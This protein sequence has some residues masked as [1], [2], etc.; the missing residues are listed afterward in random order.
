MRVMET[1]IVFVEK[2]GHKED[3]AWKCQSAFEA[4]RLVK[5][6]KDNG[7]TARLITI[8]EWNA[9]PEDSRD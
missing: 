9:L 7:L 1:D 5:F 4:E 3:R 6:L 8:A 2:S